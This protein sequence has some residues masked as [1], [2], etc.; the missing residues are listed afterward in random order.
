MLKKI[1]YP[2][3]RKSPIRHK[4]S[5]HTRRGRR[6][7]TYL[8]GTGK[9]PYYGLPVQTILAEKRRIKPKSYTVNF[10]YSSKPGDGE[11]VVVISTNYQKALDEAFEEKVDSR[12]P[13]S[14]EVIDPDLGRVFRAVGS[15]LK[16]VGKIGAK[17]AVKGL[18]AGWRAA[19]ITGKVA[20]REAA[21][22]FHSRRIKGLVERSY[23]EDEAIRMKA[24]TI[25]KSQFPD[26]YAICDFS[27][28]KAKPRP[29]VTI[30][31]PRD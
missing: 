20:A 1:R 9:G 16:K 6:V 10:R 2:N 25:L 15:G 12:N 31:I 17:Y 27:K 7:Q 3:S 26:L 8:R 5:S 19:K 28:E 23:S 13:I 30:T 29:G 4:V 24:R 18:Q 11:S 21:Y 14:V 22:Q